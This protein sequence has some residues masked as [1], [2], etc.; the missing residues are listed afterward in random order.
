MAK[1]ILVTGGA[2]YIGSHTAK[3]LS[4][5]GYRPVTYD[6]L[7]YGHRHAVKW[8][9]FVEGDIADTP[10]LEQ[11]I[12]DEA[13]DAVVHFAAFAYVGE[14]VTK[15]EIY[16]QNN[17]V[18]SLSL[19][20][21][22]RHTGVKPIVFS[23]T[24]ATYGMPDRM[25]ITEE[26][27]QRPINPYGETKL[28]IERALAWYGPAH[29][30]RSVSLRYFNAC[31]ADPEGE[32]GEEH[33]PE[34]HLIPLILDAA[35]GKRAAIDVFGTDYPTPD[36]TA[37]RDY[38]HVQD[39]ADAHVKALAYLFD[40]GATTQVNLGTGTGNSV[41][42][43][44]DAVERVTGRT[45]P[46]REVARRAGDPPELVADPSK[47]NSLLGWKPAMSDIDS[48]IRTAWAWHTR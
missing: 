3:A 29:D 19:L 31:G 33:D 1:N 15:P 48:I 17:V 18:G 6:S 44:I 4:R 26:T 22:M 32:I 30:I 37:V 35:L 43:V 25:P 5:A 7:V 45:V 14:S 28:M 46:R 24:C 41:R 20:D 39:L 11:V 36:G 40:G 12:K 34:T 16:F 10:K 42:E 21:A 9:P 8:G 23:S 13:I 27:L 38:I 47:A 2:G